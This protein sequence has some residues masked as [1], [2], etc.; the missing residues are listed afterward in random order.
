[1][2]SFANV[3][4]SKLG[5]RIG[6]AFSVT[7]PVMR[8]QLKQIVSL[9]EIIRNG[10]KFS[11]GCGVMGSAIARQVQKINNNNKS[12]NNNNGSS[13]SNRR[14]PGSI[15]IRLGGVKGMLTL[16]EDFPENCIGIRPSMCKFASN[17]RIL[18]VKEVAQRSREDVTLFSSSL[19][20]MHYLK[21]PSEAFMDLQR[22]A[23]A[24]IALK[25]D[26]STSA[27][28]LLK[29]PIDY[30]R[31]SEYVRKVTNSGRKD[32]GEYF[33]VNALTSI[34]N[35]MDLKKKNSSYK[36]G[37]DCSV[38]LMKGICDEFNFLREGEVLV[39]NGSKRGKVLLCRSPCNHPGDVQVAWAVEGSERFEALDQIIIFSA[40][41]SRPLSDVSN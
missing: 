13:N 1:L 21:V 27:R 25:W 32:N 16:K 15:L 19:L 12:S 7:K 26:D 23:W 35:E 2:G 10:Y 24:R 33:S 18:E 31:V 3:S 30:K 11:D 29:E 9:P 14:P 40:E 4:P 20:V 34:V 38:T 39:G 17:H 8:L 22:K 28:G 6:L 5:D 36:M 41:G 37:L